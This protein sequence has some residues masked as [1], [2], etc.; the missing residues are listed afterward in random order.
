MKTSASNILYAFLCFTV[1]VG[2]VAFNYTFFPLKQP[3]PFPDTYSELVTQGYAVPYPVSCIVTHT[4][5]GDPLM[6]SKI[7][8]DRTTRRPSKYECKWF[9]RVSLNYSKFLD[10]SRATETHD[11]IFITDYD[12]DHPRALAHNKLLYSSCK[13]ELDARYPNHQFQFIPHCP[14]T[15]GPQ[16]NPAR[17]PCP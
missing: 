17:I 16:L 12:G 11:A 4:L 7:T 15:T 5:T 8:F 1:C 6:V 9:D 3:A 2:I 10:L 14:T 13:A